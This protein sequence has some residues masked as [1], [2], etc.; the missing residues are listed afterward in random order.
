MRTRSSILVG[1]ALLGASAGSA[2]AA[3]TLRVQVD[4]HGDFLLIGNTLGY[5]CAAGT[6]APVVG[7]V[8]AN[9]CNQGTNVADTAPDLLWQAD[10]PGAGQALADPSTTPAQARSTAVLA[11]P[12]GATVTHAFLYWGATNANGTPDTSVIVERPG[13][14]GFSQTLTAVGTFPAGANNAYQSVADVTALVQQYGPG[15]YRVSDIDVVQ[16]SN[17]NN[18]NVFGGWAMV[19]FYQRA[20]DPLRN[21]A[22][23]EGMDVVA[24]G[25]NQSI[26]LNGFLVPN[27]GY[28]GKLGVI[29]Y[30][31]DNS[32]VGDQLLFNNT[33]LSNALNPPNNFFN[34]TR[35]NLGAAVS[36]AGDL[37]QLSGAAQSMSGIDLDVVDITAQLTPGQTSAPVQATSTGDTYYLGAFITSISTF[38][39]DFTTSTKTGTDVNGGS[40][41]AGDVLQYTINVVNTGNDASVNTVLSDPLPMGITFVP[42]SI[43]INGVPKTDM[44][45]DDQAE[46]VAAT[47]TVVARLG[48]G[49]TA[50]MGGAMPINGTATVTFQVTVDAGFTG[51][52]Q[53]QA[54]ITAAGQLGSPSATTPTDG[55]GPAAG[56]PPTTVVVDQCATSA[57]CGGN[58]PVCNTATSPKTC[59]AC[60]QDADCGGAMSGK[61]CDTTTDTCA[62]GCRGTGG[63]GCPMGDTCT[64]MDASI[65]QC[66]QCLQDTDCGGAMSGKVCDTSTDTCADGCRGTGG[67]GCPTA[68]ICTSMDATVGQCVECLQDTD[69]GAAGG[70]GKVCD[71]ST[72]KC[73][74]GCRGTIEGNCPM[75]QQCTSMDA[76]IGQCVECLVDGDCGGA[77]SGKVCDTS[78]DKCVDGC[79]GLGGNGCPASK[80][81]TS[82][83]M[84]IGQCVSCLKDSDCGGGYSGKVCDATTGTCVDGCRGTGGNA[85]PLGQMCSSTGSSIGTCQPGNCTKDSDC[86]GPTSGRICDDTTHTCGNGCR[87]TGGN[88]CPEG[89]TCSS[90]DTSPGVCSSGAGGDGNVVV[91]EG[92]GIACA[93]SP[94]SSGGNGWLLAVAAA[95]LAA[96]RRRR[97]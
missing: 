12:N 73:V 47:R 49:A 66:V 35:S 62:D 97:R 86:G 82:M 57:D 93:A 38:K 5:E 19:V 63:N 59:V 25:N 85:C 23:F 77:T 39:P 81:C 92:N 17:L 72:D 14:N 28:S 18:S 45:G 61:V 36:V 30:E 75:G 53:N 52:L 44:I 16:F 74:D 22:L 67:N 33:V 76:S 51:N 2:H 58:T 10:A 41:L 84:S 1:L 20:T 43:K 80:Q 94:G 15:A 13:A 56:S 70:S 46:Y 29:A 87:G 54:N 27:A 95:A 83:D 91:P 26:T 3:P 69:C 37:P 42:G 40:L 24:N 68:Q 79:R 96:A 50:T 8:A 32:I 6:P 34:G 78:A 90:G 55:N 71:T 21:L 9:A 89:Q 60:L 65:G 48:V 64:S 4:Q 31:G 88:S 7:T 11:V